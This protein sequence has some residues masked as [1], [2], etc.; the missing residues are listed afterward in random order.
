MRD[1]KTTLGTSIVLTIEREGK[2]P[3]DLVVERDRALSELARRANTSSSTVVRFSQALGFE[4][5]P[6]LQQAAIEEY[7]STPASG[8]SDNASLFDFDHSEFDRAFMEILV[9]RLS[10]AN[11]RLSGV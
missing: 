3:F 8:G 6:E 1:L 10:M 5:Y 7:R 11:M 9:E 2:A 4:G